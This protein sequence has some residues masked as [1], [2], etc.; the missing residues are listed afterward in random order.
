[1]DI[2]VDIW[3]RGDNHATTEVISPVRREPRAWTDGDVAAVLI[4]M[5]RAIDRARHPD[6]AADRPVGLRGFSWIVNPFESGGVVI[7]MEMTIGA[8][9]AGPFDVAESVLSGM[10]QRAIEKWKSGEVEKLKTQSKVH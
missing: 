7:A 2:P 5:L 9:V 6:A 3:L 10:I 4:G 8:V 1:M